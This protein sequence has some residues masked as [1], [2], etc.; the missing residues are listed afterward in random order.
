MMSSYDQSIEILAENKMYKWTE[1]AGNN[2]EN[3]PK[4]S[5][6]TAGNC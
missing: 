6:L 5:D 4:N 1:N 2:D 3:L